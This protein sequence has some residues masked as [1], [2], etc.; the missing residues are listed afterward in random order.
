VE[1]WLERK[2]KKGSIPKVTVKHGVAPPLA[3]YLIKT[4]P[5]LRGFEMPFNKPLADAVVIVVAK[6]DDLWDELFHIKKDEKIYAHPE[7]GTPNIMADSDDG[8]VYEWPLRDYPKALATIEEL[9]KR[10]IPHKAHVEVMTVE[11]ND[12]LKRNGH[13]S[14]GPEDEIPLDQI[15]LANALAEVTQFRA[16]NPSE[17]A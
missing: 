1:P 16:Q 17:A 6:L 7:R 3:G 12:L 14:S 8:D 9:K 10:G 13:V 5:Q 11:K 2:R 4:C 15:D